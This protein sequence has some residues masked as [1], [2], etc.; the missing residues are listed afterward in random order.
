MNE[1][2]INI[3]QWF[4]QNVSEIAALFS[5]STISAILANILLLLKLYQKTKTNTSSTDNLNSTLL[6]SNEKLNDI[7]LLNSNINANN[8]RI[9]T[10][11]KVTSDMG[12]GINNLTK[13]INAVLDVQAIVYS[14]IKD[15]ATRTAVT[16][17]LLSAKHI[18]NVKNIDNT[19]NEIVRELTTVIPDDVVDTETKVPVKIAKTTKQTPKRY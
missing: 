3:G 18:D 12:I 8:N 15:E 10:L 4:S 16:S 13:K 2:M 5:A 19:T 11:E 9:D 17:I 1:F 14:S 6:L 7:T